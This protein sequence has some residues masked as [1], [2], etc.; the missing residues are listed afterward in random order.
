MET[1][2]NSAEMENEF[3][4]VFCKG[5]IGKFAT[6]TGAHALTPGDIL[7]FSGR[8]GG[9]LSAG[10]K[11]ECL[12]SCFSVLFE[13]LFPLFKSDEIS[14]LHSVAA[15]FKASRFYSKN[16]PLAAETRRL[17]DPVQ[18]QSDLEHRGQLLRVVAAILSEE[19]KGL[20]DRRRSLATA[21]DHMVQ[22]FERL[23]SSELLNLS[24]DELAVK[25]SC[26]RRH[27][28]RLFHQHFGLS[29]AALR[30]EMRLLKA[31]SLLRD[32]QAKVINV[33]E[34]CGFN[35]LG[36]F[37]TCFKRRYGASPGQWRKLVL[38]AENSAVRKS[39]EKPSCPLHANG[40]CP[41]GGHVARAT[42]PDKLAP[43]PMATSGRFA[44]PANPEAKAGAEPRP[45]TA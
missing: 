4:F 33:A 35:H 43:P 37:N 5:G 30:M 6:P 7:V 16:S 29:I 44:S 40:L 9:K 12:F 8:S 26:S 45:Y 14:L 1:W 36:L 41:W 15:N 25:F 31:V 22:V 13:H 28:N 18:K 38:N 39:D 11:S 27:L 20:Q 17:L 19:F 3:V 2:S 34:Q 10:E 21:E 23:S 32:P 42:A 24:V